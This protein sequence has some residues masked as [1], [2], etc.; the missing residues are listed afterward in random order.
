MLVC[1]ELE[2]EGQI[3]GKEKAMTFSVID[4]NGLDDR[5]VTLI[6]EAEEKVD[7]VY[8][9]I[10]LIVVQAAHDKLIEVPPPILTRSWAELS[11]GMHAFHSA[12]KITEIPFPYPY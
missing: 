1:A 3:T 7:L 4:I 5:S 2:A 8:Q 6:Q 10:Q 12:M 11:A 9:W